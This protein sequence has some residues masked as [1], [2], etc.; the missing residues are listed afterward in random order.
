MT[1]WHLTAVLVILALLL[2]C[3]AGHPKVVSIAV[4]PATATAMSSSHATVAYSATGTFDAGDS[5]YNAYRFRSQKR[6]SR[7]REDAYE[8]RQ[9]PRRSGGGS[10]H[11]RPVQCRRGAGEGNRRGG[12]RQGKGSGQHPVEDK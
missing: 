2:G 1:S 3:G 10:T 6:K 12:R 4:S 8:K 7:L 11:R 5:A 9:N